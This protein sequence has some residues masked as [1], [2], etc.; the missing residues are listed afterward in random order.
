MTGGT[1]DRTGRRRTARTHPFAGQVLFEGRPGELP[2]GM[3]DPFPLKLCTVRLVDP[4]TYPGGPPVATQLTDGRGRF[5]FARDELAG[6]RPTDLLLEVVATNP[7]GLHLCHGADRTPWAFLSLEPAGHQMRIT[8]P[9]DEWA[10][11]E[12]W[13]TYPHVQPTGLQEEHSLRQAFRAFA[14]LTQMRAWLWNGGADSRVYP[15]VRRTNVVYPA[16]SCFYLDGDVFL[17]AATRRG[18]RREYQYSLS[19]LAHEFG[20]HV[21]AAAAPRAPIPGGQHGWTAEL[22]AAG[23][24]ASLLRQ[25]LAMDFSEAYATFIGQSFLGDRTYSY[26]DGE[27]HDLETPPPACAGDWPTAGYLWDLTDGAYDVDRVELPF[28]DVHRELAAFAA[29]RGHRVLT[30]PDFHEHLKR[31]TRLS[32]SAADLDVLLARNNLDEAYRRWGALPA[33]ERDH[34]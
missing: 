2:R 33:A 11:V 31:S 25:R 8:V 21:V 16:T 7:R 14:V 34:A 3:E 4:A 27:R 28:G 18:M 32:A 20:H 10:S 17:G 12:L 23:A 5:A 19:G 1:R 29:A 15:W 24:P 22:P 30:L 26:V 13:S 9:E 6:R